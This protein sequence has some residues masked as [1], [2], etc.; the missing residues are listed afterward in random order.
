MRTF[1]MA[2]VVVD[3]GVGTPLGGAL[4]VSL[5]GSLFDTMVLVGMGCVAWAL[6]RA[7]QAPMRS[8]ATK[9]GL[10]GGAL[11][12]DRTRRVALTHGDVVV[13]GGASRLNFHGIAPLKTG[14]HPFAGECRINLTFRKAL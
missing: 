8:R 13:W 6:L 2:L 10:F 11:R 9:I 7:R 14:S 3:L 12:S 4:S 1:P 5:C